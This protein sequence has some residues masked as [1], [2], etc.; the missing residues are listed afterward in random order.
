LY[1]NSSGFQSTNFSIYYYTFFKDTNFKFSTKTAIIFILCY[2]L[3]TLYV[4]LIALARHTLL[5]FLA[6]AVGCS[7]LQMCMAYAVVLF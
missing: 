2:L 5:Q 3:A 4:L 7:E 6:D 1:K